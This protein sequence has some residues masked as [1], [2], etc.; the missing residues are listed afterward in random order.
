M[1]KAKHVVV[2][3]FSDQWKKTYNELESQKERRES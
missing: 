1:K 3:Y 2:F